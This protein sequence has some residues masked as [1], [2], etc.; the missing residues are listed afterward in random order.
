[1]KNRQIFL[2]LDM[3]NLLS[4]NGEDGRLRHNRVDCEPGRIPWSAKHVLLGKK[5][6]EN[7]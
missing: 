3:H 6:Q 5:S 1:M 7:L 4:L 2:D